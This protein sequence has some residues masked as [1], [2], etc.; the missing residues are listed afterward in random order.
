MGL[1]KTVQSVSFL[2]YLFHTQ[3][4]YGPFL[5]VVPLSTI[6]AWAMQFRTWAPDLNVIVYMGSAASRDMIRQTEFGPLKNL[7][8]NVLLTTYEFILKDRQDLQQIKWQA[9]EVDEVSTY[10]NNAEAMADHT[11]RTVSRTATLSSTRPS[12]AS[13]LVSVCSSLVPRC[14]TTSRVSC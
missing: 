6:N 5:V 12:R 10:E 9:L 13:P 7:R 4:Q 2:S 1:G 14:R 11:R 3:Q 8:F